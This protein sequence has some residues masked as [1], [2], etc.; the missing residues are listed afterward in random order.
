MP[1]TINLVGKKFGKLKVIK[2]SQERGNRNQIKWECICDCGNKHLVTGESLRSGKSK[3]CGCLKEE[4][5]PKNKM[6]N[7]EIAILK[8]LYSQIVKRHNKKFKTNIIPFEIYYKIVKSKCVYCGVDSSLIVEDRRC[9]TK[10]K[11]LVS[12]TIIKI[13]GVDRIDSNKGYVKNN[14]VPCC[15]YCNTAKNTMTKQEFINWIKKVYD[16]NF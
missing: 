1:T 10:S 13:N 12:D 14:V 7:R 9:F 8:Y 16:Y 11:G 5:A 6:K 15:K 2:Q 3:S 4:Y